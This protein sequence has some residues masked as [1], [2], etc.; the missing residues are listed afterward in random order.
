MFEDLLAEQFKGKEKLIPLNIRALQMGIDYV[1]QHFSY[2]LELRVERRDL[3]KDSIMIDGNSA[4][5]L[6]AVYAGATVVAWYPITPS[7]SVIEA[8]TDYAAQYRM[9]EKTGQKKIC[10]GAGRR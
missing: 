2:P 7:T 4:C 1:H 10:G 9:D 8:F 5:G 3:I 6:G